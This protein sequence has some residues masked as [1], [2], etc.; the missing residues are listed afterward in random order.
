LAWAV[1]PGN[2]FRKRFSPHQA[3]HRATQSGVS[4]QFLTID[5]CGGWDERM[6]REP[7]HQSESVIYHVMAIGE[8]ELSRMT[9]TL[10]RSLEYLLKTHNKTKMN[11]K[12]TALITGANKGIELETARQLGKEGITVLVGARDEKKAKGAAEELRKEGIDAHGLVIDAD[13]SDSIQKAV[14]RW[15]RS[16]GGSTS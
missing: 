1:R 12:R 14:P 6:P 16:M 15:S 13:S 8:R 7:G 11:D 2:L 9:E 10:K 3:K 4:Q 5:T